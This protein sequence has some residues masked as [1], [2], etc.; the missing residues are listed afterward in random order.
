MKAAVLNGSPLQV[1]MC[2]KTRASVLKLLD[3]TQH[4]DFV[5]WN[6]TVGK[7]LRFFLNRILNGRHVKEKSEQDVYNKYIQ[8]FFISRIENKYFYSSST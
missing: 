2:L 4:L 7:W 1:Q 8:L 6:G 3:Q 5:M